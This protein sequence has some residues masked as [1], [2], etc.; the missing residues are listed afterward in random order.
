MNKLSKL[1]VSD[2][3]Q[4]VALLSPYWSFFLCITEMYGSSL[5]STESTIPTSDPLSKRAIYTES[6][7]L[8]EAI[9]NSLLP[10]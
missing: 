9:I 8:G 7:R 5:D 10:T 6:K 1:N 4:L 2:L 3:S